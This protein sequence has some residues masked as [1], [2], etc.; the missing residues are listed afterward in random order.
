MIAIFAFPKSKSPI[1]FLSIFENWYQAR[2][3]IK[4]KWLI[5]TSKAKDACTT[6]SLLKEEDT[7]AQKDEV[8]CPRPQATLLKETL[9]A[10]WLAYRRYFF[11]TGIIQ[12]LYLQPQLPTPQKF[13]LSALCTLAIA[14]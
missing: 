10:K 12:S 2:S 11:G 1:P 13:I 5:Q 9:Q 3:F 14:D 7:E 4:A 6:I 8:A